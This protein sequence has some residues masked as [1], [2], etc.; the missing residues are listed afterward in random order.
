MDRRK[1]GYILLLILSLPSLMLPVSASTGN[2]ISNFASN[3]L[4]IVPP[5]LFIM[6]ILALRKADYDYAFT[7]LLASII[8]TVALSAF[9]TQVNSQG[10]LFFNMGVTLSGPTSTTVN[11][12]VRYN[13]IYKAFPSGFQTN[14]TVPTN[15]AWV[16][17][18]NST[19]LVFNSKTGYID[20]NYITLNYIFPTTIGFTP[21]QVGTYTVSYTAEF[22]G[23]ID[24][25]PAVVIGTGGTILQVNPPLSGWN[26]F[27]NAVISGIESFVNSATGLFL[28]ASSLLASQLTPVLTYMFQ[29][30][31]IDSPWGNLVKYTYDEILETSVSLSLLLVAGTVAYNAL[32]NNYTD[33]IDVASDLL[34]KLGVWMLFTFGGLEI[35]NY[36]ALFINGLINEIMYPVLPQLGIELAISSGVWIAILIAPDAIPFFGGSLK[37][38]AGNLAELFLISNVIITVRYFM[39]LAIVAL[40]PLLATLWIFE[41]TRKIADALVDILIGLITAGLVNAL[42]FAFFIAVGAGITFFLL[43]LMTDVGTLISIFLSIFTIKPHERIPGGFRKGSGSG[44]QSSPNQNPQAPPAPSSSPQT[45]VIQPQNVIIQ[46]QNIGYQNKPSGSPTTYI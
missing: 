42:L 21:K 18:Y 43:P 39:I 15:Y 40:I 33:L 17:Y 4:I 7:L 3:L 45:V 22:Y 46:S 5:V 16:I 20:G 41:W 34:Y 19:I 10:L 25:F 2:P 36:V 23:S 12:N 14:D 11:S 13:V 31:T 24:N 29:T 37:V 26:W 32:R 35:Y 27:T 30:P 1:A 6:S 28:D 9:Q 44:G 8:V 38:L